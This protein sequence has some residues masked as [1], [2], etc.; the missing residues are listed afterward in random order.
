MQ[1]Q[2]KD[3]LLFKYL[4]EEKYIHRDLIKKYL[5]NRK[6][7]DGYNM[8]YKDF[9]LS[10][11]K[12]NDFIYARPDPFRKAK[13]E[14]IF[15]TEKALFFYDTKFED[16][17]KQLK[18]RSNSKLKLFEP[19]KYKIYDELDIKEL[20]YKNYITECRFIMENLG[21]DEWRND[22][23]ITINTKRTQM[24]FLEFPNILMR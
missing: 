18:S 24:L 9:R 23:F 22:L 5:Y 3:M 13:E 2:I 14:I 17:R 11:L 12:K 8:N 21:V 1:L 20:V 15:P 10:Q 7:E 6:G 4:F 19:R 16:F